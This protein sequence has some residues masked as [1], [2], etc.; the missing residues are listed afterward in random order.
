VK[1]LVGVTHSVRHAH[2]QRLDEELSQ[3]VDPAKPVGTARSA[4]MSCHVPDVTEPSY[5]IYV[6]VARR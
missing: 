5:R 3:F 1:L 6:G 4:R 2:A